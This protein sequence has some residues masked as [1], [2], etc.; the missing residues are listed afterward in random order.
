MIKLLKSQENIMKI[1]LILFNICMDSSYIK[2]E[3]PTQDH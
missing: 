3:H 2:C 1:T